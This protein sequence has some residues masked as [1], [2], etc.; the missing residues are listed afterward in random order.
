MA[1]AFRQARTRGTRRRAAAVEAADGGAPPRAGRARV[2][3]GRGAWAVGSV[4]TAVARLVRLVVELIVLVIVVAI[5]LRVFGANPANPVVMD[6]HDV[7]RWFV[8]PFSNMF[9]IHNPKVAI[10]VNWGIAALVYQVL[11]GLIARLIARV[12]PRGVAP[13]EPV[14]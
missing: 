6:V 3:A 13:G 1:F 7:A 11:G 9:S 12:A 14:V 2:A 8:G 5:L 10:A 4:V